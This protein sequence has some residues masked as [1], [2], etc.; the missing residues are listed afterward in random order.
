[1]VSQHRHIKVVPS[2]RTPHPITHDYQGIRRQLG[3][4]D[5]KLETVLAY[6]IKI[7]ERSV[8]LADLPSQL[9][10]GLERLE[11]KIKSV[12]DVVMQV[13]GEGLLNLACK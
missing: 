7:E 11:S 8:Q 5:N 13:G 9:R 12:R 4:M 3:S 6:V 10:E 2:Q 1:M